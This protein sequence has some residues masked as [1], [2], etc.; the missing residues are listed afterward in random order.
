MR[1]RPHLGGMHSGSPAAVVPAPARRPS[2]TLLRPPCTA[3]PPA[4][5]R[6]APALRGPRTW[7]CWP[8]APWPAAAGDGGVCL[9]GGGERPSAARAPAVQPAAHRDRQEPQACARVY[10]LLRQLLGRACRVGHAAMWGKVGPLLPPR[11]RAAATV[12][13]LASVPAAS[14]PAPSPSW[15]QCPRSPR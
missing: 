3:A 15:S 13:R 10:S 14:Q 1:R 9:G 6:P 12:C 4:S 5:S 11:R 2:W 7:R 8:P